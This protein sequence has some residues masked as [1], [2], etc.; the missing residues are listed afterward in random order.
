MLDPKSTGDH[1][2]VVINGR[3]IAQVDSYRYLG[4]HNDNKLTWVKRLYQGPT[5][6]VLSL[7]AESLWCQ[8]ESVAS[9]DL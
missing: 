7:T 6:S 3:N 9:T 8:P 4:I 5:A 1:S 2:T